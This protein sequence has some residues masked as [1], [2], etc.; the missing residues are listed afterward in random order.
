[1]FG[2]GVADLPDIERG[3]ALLRG[4]MPR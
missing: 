3:L 1:L 4:A 2:F